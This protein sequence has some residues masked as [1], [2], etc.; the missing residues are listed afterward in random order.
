M[1]DEQ[2]RAEEVLQAVIQG[3]LGLTA[4]ALLEELEKLPGGCPSVVKMTIPSLSDPDGQV[5]VIV[6]K[7]DECSLAL[8]STID[9]LGAHFCADEG[10][11]VEGWGPMMS[12]Q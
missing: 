4:R 10:T 3:G 9:A 1:S 12:K 5:L 6:V 11:S 7:D 2:R 8:L